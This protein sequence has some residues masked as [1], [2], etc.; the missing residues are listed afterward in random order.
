MPTADSVLTMSSDETKHG[1]EDPPH[2][3]GKVEGSG[4]SLP[5]LQSCMPHHIVGMAGGQFIE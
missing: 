3:A 5:S 4:D 2:H 1:T